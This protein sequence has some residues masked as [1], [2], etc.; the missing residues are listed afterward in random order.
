MLG[1]TEENSK[2]KRTDEALLLQWLRHILM[3]ECRRHI[4]L[5][6][7]KITQIYCG[8]MLAAT[9]KNT[10][11]GEKQLLSKLRSSYGRYDGEC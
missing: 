9:H 3:I 11:K 5:R 2:C 7:K 10:Q 1:M 4:D 6:G 8:Q